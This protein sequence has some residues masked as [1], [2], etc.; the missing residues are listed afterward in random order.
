MLRTLARFRDISAIDWIISVLDE[1][2][3]R[4]RAM[5]QSS[6][7]AWAVVHPIVVA[8][9]SQFKSSLAHRAEAFNNSS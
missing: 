2:L 1:Y 6:L 4:A 5:A 7:F 8:A 9:A 3:R